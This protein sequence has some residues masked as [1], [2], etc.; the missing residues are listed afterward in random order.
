ME[1]QIDL[2]ISRAERLG[3]HLEFDCGLLIV[4]RTESSEPEMQDEMLAE[5]GNKL[6]DVRRL[7]YLRAVAARAQDFLGQRIWTEE[8]EG[9]LASAQGDGHLSISIERKDL[10][11]LQTVTARSEDL[12][13]VMDG[14]AAG[15]SSVQNDE[16]KP[17]RPRRGIFERLRGS[18]PE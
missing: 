2:L 8:G 12:L 3:L 18:R 6:S 11:H 4:K 9:K 17:E 1:K 14:E 7:V 10:R 13:I 5:L 15:A 16:S